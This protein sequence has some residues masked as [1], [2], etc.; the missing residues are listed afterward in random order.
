MSFAIMA[1]Q[2][3]TTH[4]AT[5][6]RLLTAPIIWDRGLGENDTGDR[7][8][9]HL[10][11]HSD[12]EWLTV[13]QDDALPVEGFL[14]HYQQGLASRPEGAE[15]FSW[16]LGTSRPPSWQRRVT[17]ALESA[18]DAAW[19]TSTQLLHGVAVTLHRTHVHPMLQAVK[20][21]RKAYD[22]R[23]GDY[24]H[25]HKLLVH[26]PVSSLVDH[27]DNG[28]LVGHDKGPRKAHQLGAPQW[29]TLTHPIGAPQRGQ[30]R[31]HAMGGR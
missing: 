19:L 20:A 3:R 18:G 29:N 14:T 24:L 11:E 23:I 30:G 7:A 16:Y 27:A 22:F 15:A 26:Y 21:N 28:S 5:L 12:D 13:I 8:W 25:R 1:H 2:S 6:S 9:A 17:D 4:A 31:G 10:I